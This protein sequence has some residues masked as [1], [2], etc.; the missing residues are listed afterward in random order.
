MSDPAISIMRDCAND[1]EDQIYAAEQRDNAIA[2]LIEQLKR[3]EHQ[4]RIVGDFLG[5]PVAVL[6]AIFK[7]AAHPGIDDYG[8]GVVIHDLWK[9][10]LDEAATFMVDNG[11]RL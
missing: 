6:T 1:L 11:V 7:L 5:D 8:L 4:E 2:N 3:S 10:S 9:T